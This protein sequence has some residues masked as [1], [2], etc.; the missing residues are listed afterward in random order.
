V[1]SIGKLGKGQE[2]YYLATVAKGVEDYYTGAGEAPGEWAGQGAARLGLSGQVDPDHLRAI[3]GGVDPTSGAVLGGRTRSDRVPGWDLTFSAPKSVSVLYGLGGEGVSEEVVA[4][5]KAAVADAL[6]YLE[7]H[8]TVSR[9]RVDGAIEVVRGEGLVVA[10]F[11]HR[12]S[13]AGD[14]HLHTHCL[15]A[16]VVE[17][18][19]GGFGALHS[20][21]IYRHA[22]TAGFVYQVVLRAELTERLGVSWGEVHHGYAEIDG[23]DAQ[24]L[25]RFSKRRAEIEAELEARGEDSPGAAR[26]ATL[27]TRAAKDY[28]V[29]PETLAE[30]WRAEAAEVG[31]GPA[32]LA[33]ALGHRVPAFA[34]AQLDAAVEDLAG[35]QGLTADQASFAR[36]DVVRAWCE[37]LPAG[38]AV[39]LEGLEELTEAFLED[40]QVVKVRDTTS[41]LSA[42]QLLRRADGTATTAVAVERRWSTTEMLDVE[43]RLLERA[44]VSRGVGVGQVDAELIEA[45]LAVAPS[46]S[47]EQAAMVRAV[48]GSG[49]GVQVV[50]GRAGTGK[51]YSLAAAAS[52]WRAG[53]YR[54]VGVALAARAAVELETAAAIPS[55]TLAQFLA[56]CDSA[57]GLLD[58]RHVVVVD[59]AA[60]VDTR[61]LARL[62]A[63]VEAAGAKVVLVGDHHQLPAVEAGGAFAGLVGRLGATELTE[64][65]RQRHAWERD[66]LD[67]LRTGDGGRSGIVSVIDRYDAAGRLHVGTSTAEVRRAMVAD[68]Y[69]ARRSGEAVAMLALRHRDV[70]Q[71][72]ALAR[73]LLVADG[74]VAA[75][76]VTAAGRTFA[77]GDRVVCLHND[78]R[79]GVHNALFATVVATDAGDGSLVVETSDRRRMVLPGGYLG[80]GHLDHAYATT[81]HK[82]QGATYG[83]TL[84]L[85][86]DRLYREAGYTGLSRGRDRNDFYVVA[87]D[88]RDLDADLEP[89]GTAG[90]E[91]PRERLVRALQRSGAKR[92][93][94]D[95]YPRRE[96]S[97]VRSLGDLMIEQALL[98]G[99][100]PSSPA[101]VTELEL[102]IAWRAERAAR[103]AEVDRQSL[104]VAVLGDPPL[105]PAGREAWRRAAVSIEIE[106]V[107]AGL[108]LAVDAEWQATDAATKSP[109]VDIATSTGDGIDLG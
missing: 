48:C 32:H 83:R 99:A 12:T 44:A 33:R 70:D 28:G 62:V 5:H 8:A 81:I 71:L 9:R 6:R 87:D 49:D 100:E 64:N 90:E 60:M 35:P 103:A 102:Q 19:D 38:V 4:A 82:S 63:H 10:A 74:T 29:D 27:V 25:E 24:L 18:V 15:A 86:D 37:A 51:T 72:N 3:L 84:L 40:D 45:R 46:L 55:T 13:R 56:D 108:G 66:A 94:S 95:E 88:D 85:G 75:A 91:N 26:V 7:R 76:G 21:F 78:A 89:H 23:I 36:R 92:L 61:R 31:F 42:S 104:V 65:R 16:N 43:R 39:D 58:H 69:E 97:A 98:V 79:I 22:R 101:S 59:E 80:A 54:P 77:I 107:R 20:P 109:P 96:P 105:D 57:G 106:H 93:A 73:S 1:L 53:G 30:R 11:R 2:N 52:V 41:E 14:P 50:V 47:G 34:A 68:W 67:R 17:H